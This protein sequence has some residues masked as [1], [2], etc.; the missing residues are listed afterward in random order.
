MLEFPD[1]SYS[2]FCNRPADRQ[3]QLT[4]WMAIGYAVVLPNSRIASDLAAAARQMKMTPHFRYFLRVHFAE[5]DAQKVVFNS[6]Y[7]HY[8]DL[9]AIEFMRSLG[10]GEELVTGGLDYQLV[11]QTIEWKALHNSTR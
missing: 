8:V 10:Y 2:G 3:H 4:H 9:A 6:H 5:C 1:S 7:G 11:K